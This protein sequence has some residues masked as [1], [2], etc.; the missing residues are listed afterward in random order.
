[1]ADEDRTES[2]SDGGSAFREIEHTADRALCIRGR[3]WGELL[4][5]AARGL[6]SLIGAQVDPADAPRTRPLKIEADDAESLLVEWLT[7]LAFW[8]EDSGFVGSRFQFEKISATR[9]EARISGRRADRI[10]RHVKAVTYHDLTVRQSAGGLEVT[11]VF[12]V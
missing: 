12:D 4:Q 3:D 1:M 8:V 9:L 6:Y 7:E 10:E 5:H 11:V 2:R